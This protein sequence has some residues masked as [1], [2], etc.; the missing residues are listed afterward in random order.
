[1]TYLGENSNTKVKEVARL[2]N[3]SYFRLLARS[4]GR[5]PSSSRGGHNKK[6]SEPEDSALKDYLLM[7][8][9]AGTPAN[10]NELHKAANRL[11]YFKGEGEEVSSRW[12]RRWLIRN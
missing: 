10:V 11:L 5:R 4:H 2:F 9:Y 1:M 7:L 3:C 8:Y 12:A 6:L